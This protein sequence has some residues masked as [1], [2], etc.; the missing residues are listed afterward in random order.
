[1]SDAFPIIDVHHH[2]WDL[3]TGQYPWLEG[4]FITTFRYGDYRP[5][6]RNYLPDDFRRDSPKQNVTASV[7]MEAA[8]I[9]SISR[10][11]P[12]TE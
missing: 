7:H 10:S 8:D 5:I 2:L 4:E 12:I 3:E 9:R 11:K 1:M 6:C